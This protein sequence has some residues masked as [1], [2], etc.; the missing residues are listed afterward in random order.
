MNEDAGA[1]GDDHDKEGGPYSLMNGK[2]ANEHEEGHL[3]EAASHTE[4]SREGS[5]KTPGDPDQEIGA[6][7]GRPRRRYRLL[8]SR[9]SALPNEDPSSNQEKEQGIERE[10]DAVG[11]VTTDP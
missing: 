2:T 11:R 6:N 9:G 3:H 10:Q 8:V 5:R 4:E 1:R 7:T